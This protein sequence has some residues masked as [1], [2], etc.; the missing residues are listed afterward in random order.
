MDYKKSV[1]IFFILVLSL[2]MVENVLAALNNVEFT[3]P[4]GGEKLK[5][6]VVVTWTATGSSTGLQQLSYIKEGNMV[7]L[8]VLPSVI[9]SYT[10][11][12][13]SKNAGDGTYQLWIID[14]SGSTG[15]YYD[16]SEEFVI[17]NTAPTVVLSDNHADAIVRDADTVTI[18]AT[19]TETGSGITTPPT[20]TIG[21]LISNAA[22]TGAGNTWTYVW[23]VPAGAD[24]DVT[25][26]IA[27][28]D[29]AGN[30]NTAATG[31]TTYTIDNTAPTVTNYT[32]EINGGGPTSDNN[33]VFSPNGDGINDTVSIDVEF[34]E[35]ATWFIEIW[36][37]SSAVYSWNEISQ[38]PQAKIWNGTGNTGN[39]DYTI[40]ITATDVAG[41]QIT[42]TE[43]KITL[44]TTIY[45]DA[46]GT[47]YTTIQQAISV[48]NPGDIIEVAAGTYPGLIDVNVENVVI[49][50]VGDTTIIDAG[51]GN[52]GFKITANN[53]E[54]Q[55]LKIQTQ[56]VLDDTDDTGIMILN[57]DNVEISGVKIVSTSGADPNG[58]EGSLGIWI[59]GT[60]SGCD[61]S[62]NIIINQNTITI[63]GVS[64]GIYSEPANPAHSGWQITDNIVT[65]NSGVTIELYDVTNSE[66]SMNT[67]NGS[68]TNSN[69]YWSSQRS[70]IANLIFN[71]NTL[72][73]SSGSMVVIMADVFLLGDGLDNTDVG[74]VTITGNTFSDWG[75]KALRIGENVTGVTVNYNKFLV[76]TV[77]LTILNEDASQIDAR[78]NWWVTINPVW[79][80]LVS[81][82]ILTTPF[83][84]D[85]SL[86]R[87]Y[88]PVLGAVGN[89]V[90]N[91]GDILPF[92]LTASDSDIGDIL[93]FSDDFAS[94]SLDGQ[95]GEF[96]WTPTDDDI[97]P[98]I[99]F[100]V[101]DDFMTDSETINITVNNANPVVE[102]GTDQNV[103]EG[104]LVTINPTFTDAGADTHNATINW[105]DGSALEDISSVTS[106]MTRTHTYT[107]NG[108]YTITVTI[109]DDDNGVSTD[110]LTITVNNIA[111]VVEA[112]ANQNANK[113]VVIT[114]N[115][116]FTD[117]GADTHNATINWGDG[118]S[119]NTISPA[120][121]PM[122]VTH[123]Y[124]NNEVYTIIVSVTDDD[125][126]IGTDTLAVTVKNLVLTFEDGWN[127]VSVPKT[128][129]S[130]VRETVFPASNFDEVYSFNAITN[131]WNTGITAI[132]PG[133]GYWV[134][135]ITTGSPEEV[136]LTYKTQGTDPEIPSETINLQ[137][138]WNLMG[139]MCT[140]TQ[141]PTVAF[142]TAYDYLFILRYDSTS[143]NFVIHDGGNFNLTPGEGYWIFLVSGAQ[144]PYT[145][146]C[147]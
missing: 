65:A 80:S 62:N 86:T 112:G 8:V 102:A 23:D 104:D 60:D 11:D 82:D 28:T 100:T 87:F 123:N 95:T 27:A 25:V 127:L 72:K 111:P 143:G 7:D 120:T 94:G 124:T 78:Y 35:G 6:N 126:G 84:E 113:D 134:N 54:I 55:N 32:L 59:C 105:G 133:Y 3:Y 144:L 1:L 99:T 39:K 74:S 41:N 88:A 106:P 131:N 48:A 122:T 79:A 49:K 107:D 145:N 12:S 52:Y 30:S 18:T 42:N 14:S 98:P 146:F 36:D 5:G 125:N 81:G 136:G 85:V 53:V 44:D 66:V 21:S 130:N 128:L 34:S 46:V 108:I 50:G 97:D 71:N 109:T 121:S 64:T 67:L 40:K 118:S 69:F 135:K 93:T 43:K 2:L 47:G 140:N 83:A 138:G 45:V 116:T 16:L 96:T 68:T 114:I 141:S 9:R 20:I 63:N 117:A 103:N 56:F 75:S 24:G 132:D 19:F 33:V 4:A 92:T 10:W 129:E 91:E 101:S 22:M 70:N 37:E 26:S 137:P 58:A 142:G 38:N 57:A 61:G 13:I 115:P 29:V 51:A 76:T 17:D 89:K 110:T 90:I 77:P 119:V 73:N 15:K 139:H 147:G 31:K